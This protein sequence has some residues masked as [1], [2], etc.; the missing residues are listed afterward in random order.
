MSPQLFAWLTA[1]SFACANISVRRGMEY[2]TPLTATF[3]SLVIHTVALWIAVA[4]TVGI[5]SVAVTAVVAI[6][7][8]GIVQPIMRH[9]HYT[10][11]RKIG[12][13]RA[14]TLRNTFPLPA[15]L[16]G[17][18]ILGEPITPLGM[19]G[20]LL[21]VIGIVFTSWRIDQHITSFRWTY[22]LYPIATAL[23]TA[24]VHPLRRYAMLQSHEPLF[25]TAIVGPVS[26]LSFAMYYA[27]P[28]CDEKL[29]WDRR[30]FWPFLISGVFETAAVLLMLFA[31]SL[32]PVVIVS[33]IA[34]TTPIWTAILSA[35]FLRK[36]ERI[37][38]ASVI[39]TVCV[40]AGVIAIS[41]SG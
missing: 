32:G 15:V 40:V 5:P 1:V 39:G 19:I 30:A 33:P 16:I 2:S 27:L 38:L 9:C 34:S 29:V 20:T 6:V 17:I 28:M 12:T 31:F 24:V 4:L 13:S 41:L 3:V 21:V 14:V 22:L 36:I 11:I 26:L 23:I 10:G 7:F 25:F 35:I 18:L 8:T 37:N